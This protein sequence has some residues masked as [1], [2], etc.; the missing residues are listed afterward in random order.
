MSDGRRTG[1]GRALDRRRT[2]VGQAS[3]GSWTNLGQTAELWHVCFGLSLLDGTG[4]YIGNFL[5]GIEKSMI[6]HEFWPSV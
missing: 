3:D 5:L 4:I 2:G 6:L 1:V